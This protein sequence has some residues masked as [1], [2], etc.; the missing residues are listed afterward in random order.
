V[1]CVDFSPDMLL[2]ARR[3]LPTASFVRAEV[4][5]LPFSNRSFQRVFT[6]HFYGHLEKE[7][8]LFLLDEVR[9][10]GTE[11]LIVVDSA[12]QPGYPAE[13]WEERT[14]EDGSRFVIWKRHFTPDGL[15]REVGADRVLFAGSTFVAVAAWLQGP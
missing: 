6:G 9:R 10:V 1:T 8:R 13:L 15:A 4:P 2:L 7:A 14:L 12:V 5:P 3:R 11:E